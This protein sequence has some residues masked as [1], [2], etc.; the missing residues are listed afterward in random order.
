MFANQRFFDAVGTELIAG[1]QGSYSGPSSPI[2]GADGLTAGHATNGGIERPQRYVIPLGTRIMR[3]GRNILADL[4]LQGEWWLEEVELNKVVKFAEQ[5]NIGVCTAIRLLCA[6]PSEWSTLEMMV[7]AVVVGSLL[8]YRGPGNSAFIPVAQ[9][10]AAVE[11]RNT[12]GLVT[13]HGRPL[14]KVVGAQ[15]PK[16][17]QPPEYGRSEIIPVIPDT[18]GWRIRQ[19][20][21]PGLG[22]ADVRRDSLLSQGCRFLAE[23][24]AHRGYT[25]QFK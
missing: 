15:P 5:K 9:G 6:V 10:R 14:G 8:A 3:F 22:S 13:S 23:E 2:Y 4:V 21:I 24:D 18:N 20:F 25:P 7:Q 11:G 1:G 12:S 19:L 16:L 17:A